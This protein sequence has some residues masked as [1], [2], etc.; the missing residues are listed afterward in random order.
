MGSLQ[1]PKLLSRKVRNLHISFANDSSNQISDVRNKSIHNLQNTYTGCTEGDCVSRGM[2][3]K[4]DRVKQ[5]ASQH[6]SRKARRH[7]SRSTGHGAFI[8]DAFIECGRGNYAMEG[9]NVTFNVTSGQINITN[10]NKIAALSD[11]RRKLPT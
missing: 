11:K 9:T 6:A 3:C 4:N 5:K 2:N 10:E 1:N 8:K 7:S